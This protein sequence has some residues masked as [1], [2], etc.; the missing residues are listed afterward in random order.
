MARQRTAAAA[1]TSTPTDPPN[2]LPAGWYRF[3]GAY[4]VVLV[5][6]GVEVAPGDPVDWPD[7][8]PDDINWAPCE[9]PTPDTTAPTTAPAGD[10]TEES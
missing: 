6:R 5:A 9:A 2:A 4:P 10:A 1:A 3:V 7:G 8:P